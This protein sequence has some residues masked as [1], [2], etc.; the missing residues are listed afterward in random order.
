MRRV[1]KGGNDDGFGRNGTKLSAGHLTVRVATPQ[2]LTSGGGL[3]SHAV[4]LRELL[5]SD[6]M[7]IFS[8]LSTNARKDPWTDVRWAA[9]G[10]CD[11]THCD[12]PYANVRPGGEHHLPA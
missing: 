9:I 12:V 8:G 11:V 5:H 10:Q 4:H 1:V 2:N 6:H 7:A 3:Y